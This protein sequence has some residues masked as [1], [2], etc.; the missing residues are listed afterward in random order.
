MAF[1][2]GCSLLSFVPSALAEKTNPWDATGLAFA[3]I[4]AGG[5]TTDFGPDTVGKPTIGGGAGTVGSIAV[6]FAIVASVGFAVVSFNAKGGAGAAGAAV[7]GDTVG[8]AGGFGDLFPPPLA[9]LPPPLDPDESALENPSETSASGAVY[10]TCGAGVATVTEGGGGAATGAGAG[11]TMI[12]E[13]SFFAFVS[14]RYVTYPP[15]GIANNHSHMVIAPFA[16]RRHRGTRD[17]SPQ[18][19][20]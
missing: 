1:S 13:A 14:P 6:A 3:G 7:A 9:A 18:R 16:P 12:W 17:T 5:S 11:P 15:T 8:V 4:G 19:L 10:A 2:I 20:E